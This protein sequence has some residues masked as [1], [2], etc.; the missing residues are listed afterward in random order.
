[1]RG[2]LKRAAIVAAFLCIGPASAQLS[3]IFTPNAPIQPTGG[4]QYSSPQDLA[5]RSL[6]LLD[7]GGV[8]DRTTDNTT[9]LAAAQTAALAQ[10]IHVIRMDCRPGNNGSGATNCGYVFNTVQTIQSGITL[11]CPSA[12]AIEPITNPNDFTNFPNAIITPG[13]SFSAGSGF[14]GC[15]FLDPTLAAN[16]ATPTSFRQNYTRWTNFAAGGHT[17]VTCTDDG[18]NFNRGMILGYQTGVLSDGARIAFM[19]DLQIDAN[20]AIQLSHQGAG[21]IL[22]NRIVAAPYTTRATTGLNPDFGQLTLP[23]SSF[24][25]N[26]SGALQLTLTNACSTNDNCPQ[27]GDLIFVTDANTAPSADGRWIAT[28]V[29]YG[30]PT[31]VDLAFDD[32]LMTPSSA[33]LLSG[34]SGSTRTGNVTIGSTVVSNVSATDMLQLQ[35]SDSVTMPGPPSCIPS[36]TTIVAKWDRNKILYLSKAAACSQTGASLVFKDTQTDFSISTATPVSGC[37]GSS[38]IKGDVLT[39]SGG[40]PITP[41]Q[42]TVTKIGGGGCVSHANVTAGGDY[43][44]PTAP[45]TTMSGTGG[46]GTGASFTVSSGPQLVLVANS[47]SGKGLDVSNVNDVRVDDFTELNFVIGMSFGAGTSGANLD[48]VKLNGN[49]YLDDQTAHGLVL[50]GNASQVNLV[51]C[52]IFYWNGAVLDQTAPGA[53]GA[54]N[55][56]SHCLVGAPPE[57]AGF[58]SNLIEADSSGSPLS[59]ILTNDYSYTKNS[60]I[61]VN[62]NTRSVAFSDNVFPATTLYCESSAGASVISGT[63]NTILQNCPAFPTSLQNGAGARLTPTS[64][65]LYLDNV[66]CNSVIASSGVGTNVTLT[67]VLPPSPIPNCRFTFLPNASG[68]PIVVDPNGN[69]IQGN[70]FVDKT[71]VTLPAVGAG[72]PQAAMIYDGTI[73]IN[74]GG[75]SDISVMAGLS[76]GVRRAHGQVYLSYDSTHTQLQLCPYN[77]PGGLVIND[78]MSYVPATCS[79]LP[80]SAF[81]G[82]T[83]VSRY[84]YANRNIQGVGGSSAGA[85]GT[86]ITFSNTTGFQSG[87]AITC[88]G[89]TGTPGANVVDDNMTTLVDS[90]HI[91]ITDVPFVASDS[92]G[93]CVWTGLIIASNVHVTVNGVEVR[94]NIHANTL[95]GLVWIDGSSHLNDSL[96]KR[97]VASWFNP[98]PKKMLFPMTAAMVTATSTTYVTPS[99]VVEGEF[100]AF[101]PPGSPGTLPAPAVSWSLTA[102]VST[103]AVTA[104]TASLG[105]CFGTTALTAGAACPNTVETEVAT[106]TL[107]ASVSNQLFAVS[108]QTT[109]LSEGRNFMDLV[110]LSSTGTLAPE[111]NGTFIDSYLMQ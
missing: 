21:T 8:P 73:W 39:L 98:H 27:N 30:T 88:N 77:G 26:M 43:P 23:I 103:N 105:A 58:G 52:G 84:I 109:T 3:P 18:C 2:L 70:D 24:G 71:A 44:L 29:H 53:S 11:Y 28:N 82:L 86:K 16:P 106:A 100:V 1:M 6:S 38:Y 17:G 56:V 48:N 76:N 46:S 57:H 10:N 22:I 12:P 40:S 110:M 5:A 74:E 34:G 20:T 97:D 91:E 36:G 60:G 99:T 14:T 78:A 87:D 51:N 33:S 93:S 83:N 102:G 49:N 92:H 75:A 25:A 65:P 31:T 55:V 37:S 59:L 66:N 42:V 96:A 85:T 4:T 41:A 9:A 35:V 15:N 67:V 69:T 7:F 81:S 101:G 63:G 107:P 13:M 90:T 80:T 19:N 32:G 45:P 72:A 94:T 50:S 54:A 68:S 104:S 47:R 62:N 111:Q 61:F 89:L 95:V 108:G 64:S 79:L